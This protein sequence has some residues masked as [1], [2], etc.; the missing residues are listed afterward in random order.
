MP[1]E[2]QES[3]KLMQH[4]TLARDADGL[5]RLTLDR[6]GASTNTLGAPVLAELNEALD[7]L[8]RDPPRGLSAG[9]VDGGRREVDEGSERPASPRAVRPPASSSVKSA[10]SDRVHA[11]RHRTT[12]RLVSR[13]A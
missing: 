5:A 13:T 1:R 2:Q 3:G 11:G 10:G 12:A 4:W 7:L 8:E 6:A 9:E